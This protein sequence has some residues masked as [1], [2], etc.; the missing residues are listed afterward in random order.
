MD[1]LDL[2]IE[3][4]VKYRYEDKLQELVDLLAEQIRNIAMTDAAETIEKLFNSLT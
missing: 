4:L 2:L 3:E 1:A